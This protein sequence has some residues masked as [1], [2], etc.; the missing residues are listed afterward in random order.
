MLYVLFFIFGTYYNWRKFSR[1]RDSFLQSIVE[2]K[3]IAQREMILGHHFYVYIFE[4]F[5]AVV[6]AHFIT[7]RSANIGLL[8]FG[9]IYLAILFFGYFLYQFFIQ[10]IEKLTQL[11]LQVSFGRNLIKDLRVSFALILLPFFIYSIISLTFTDTEDNSWGNYWFLGYILNIIFIS[12]VTIICSVVIMLKLIPNRDISEPEYLEIIQKRLKQIKVNNMRIRWI[13]TEIKNAFVV[14][15]KILTFSNQTMFVGKKLKSILTIEEFDAV[16]AHELAH[17]ANRHIQKRVLFI[18]KNM[19]SLLL[20]VILI[21]GAG[22]IIPMIFF[23][24][25]ASLYEDLM[26]DVMLVLNFGWFIINYI[27]LFDSI[28]AQEYE[29]DAFA[30]MVLGVD[31]EVYASALS[32]LSSRDDLPDYLK[33]KSLYKE[34][35]IPRSGWRRYL[36]NAFSTHPILEDRIQSI[37]DKIQNN[38]SFDFYNSNFFRFKNYVSSLMTIKVIVPASVAMGVFLFV[39]I[40][41]TLNRRDIIRFVD[42]ASPEE[43]IAKKELI[44]LINTRFL[45]GPELMYSIVLRKD[46]KLIEYF[47]KNGANPANTILYIAMVGDTKLL[48]KFYPEIE[49]RLTGNDIYRIYHKCIKEGYQDGILLIENSKAIALMSKSQYDRIS[50]LKRHR[51]DVNRLPASKK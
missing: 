6:V 47:L 36:A 32:K 31:L 12:V 41:S 3:N 15:L 51:M 26:F 10:Y 40:N 2:S 1:E 22:I 48:N 11:D 21:L 29:A 45:G 50:E 28:K 44:S 8:G 16:I 18:I 7:E 4:T 9:L 14:G 38:N 5:L 34:A 35:K 37:K 23:G 46:E 24:V 33:T 25:E 19:L 13:E 20:G 27:S 17:V 43:I 42:N 49:P 39:A 30:V